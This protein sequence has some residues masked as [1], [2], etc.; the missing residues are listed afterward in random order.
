MKGLLIYDYEDS[1]RC[2][3]WPGPCMDGEYRV[4]WSQCLY[5]AMAE[6]GKKRKKKKECNQ[7]VGIDFGVPREDGDMQLR[8]SAISSPGTNPAAGANARQAWATM[9]YTQHAPF[10][11]PLP[12]VPRLFT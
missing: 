7:A 11:F 2:R 1:D 4:E 9:L 3:E 10:P 12:R 5:Q 6:A 8:L